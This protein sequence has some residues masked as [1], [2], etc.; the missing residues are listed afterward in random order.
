LTFHTNH[1]SV[2]YYFRAKAGYWSKIAIFHTRSAFD[3]PVTGSMF[4]YFHNF[5]YGKAKMV[6]PPD[7]SKVWECICSS[8][9]N[10]WKWR[11]DGQTDRH[12]TTA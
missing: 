10:T 8:R 2:L 1:G 9:Y 6:G 11:T 5:W 7:M 3:A 12:R 4:E